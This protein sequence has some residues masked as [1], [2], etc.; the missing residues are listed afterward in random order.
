[1]ILIEWCWDAG[2]GALAGM[3]RHNHQLE[4]LILD[5]NQ[6]GDYGG[7]AIGHALLSNTQLHQL[8]LRGNSVH[9]ATGSALVATLM[10]NSSLTALDIE[11]NDINYANNSAVK[12]L[13]AEHART[14][15]L[16]AVPRLTHELER[17][18]KEEPKLARREVELAQLIADRKRL[19]ENSAANKAECLET[20][21]Y[22]FEKLEEL[23]N[24]LSEAQLEL[25]DRKV[26]FS[27][28]SLLFDLLYYL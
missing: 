26:T 15:A 22:M 5:D 2:A 24:G 19:E 13:V 7:L 14:W 18:R 6:V 1:L 17:L 21:Q 9:D 16:S 28:V 11:A 8:S 23:D 12:K 27:N 10:S 20:T 3:L 25:A 4:T